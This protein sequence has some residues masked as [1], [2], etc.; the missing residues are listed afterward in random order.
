MAEAKNTRKKS[1]AKKSMQTDVAATAEELDRTV[2]PETAAVA[3]DKPI[4]EKPVKKKPSDRTAEP[5]NTESQD[6]IN[7]ADEKSTEATESVESIENV[8]AVAEEKSEIPAVEDGRSVDMPGEALPDDN[9]THNGDAEEKPGAHSDKPVKTPCR[10]FVLSKRMTV[11]L[12]AVLAVVV[13]AIVLAVCLTSCN[14][15]GKLKQYTVKFDTNGGSA[16][17]SY[18]LNAGSKVNRPKNDPTKDMFTF[19]DWY[20]EN[21][22]KPGV[23]QKFQF[24]TPISQNITLIAGWIGETSIKIDFDTNGGMFDDDKSVVLYGLVGS[25]LSEPQDVPARTGYVFD[26][27]YTEEECINKFTFGAYPATNVTLYAGWAKDSEYAYIS[28]YGN[29]ELLRVDAVKKGEDVVLPEL[30]DS[31]IVASDWRIYGTNKTYTAGKATEDFGLYTYY[32]TD[33]LTFSATRYAATVTGYNGMA[34]K[35]V[36]PPVYDG[37]DVTTIGADAFYRTSGLPAVT[38]ITLPDTI[39]TIGSGAFYNCQYLSSINLTNKVVTVGADA[40]YRNMRLRSLG[41]TEGITT[42]GAGAFNGCKE[43]REFKLSPLVTEIGAYTFND[44]AWL[45]KITLPDALRTLGA[46]A[47]SGCTSLK[48]VDLSSLILETV[49]DRAFAGCSN[50]TEVNIA[51]TSGEVTLQGDPFADCRNVTVYV[52]S[53]LLDTYKGNAAYDLFKDKFAVK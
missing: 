38:Q 2:Q 3:E 43:L 48:S 24:G 44:C 47:F 19:D 49:G 9:G 52:P 28:Y 4:V 29:N 33:G 39:T 40:F 1:T 22:S 5:E 21:P 53:A 37:K 20:W 46:Y 23:M 30:F 10:K 51:K 7:V 27:W 32:Y 25:S 31:T 26:G 6:E 34:T 36:V 41:D 12:A 17:S 45:A 18:K 11:I 15:N 16:L 42:I 8:E 13:I 35:V 14:G 50:L